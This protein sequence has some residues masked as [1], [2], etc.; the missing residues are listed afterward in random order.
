MVQGCQ[1]RHFHSLGVYSVPAYSNEW[2]PREMYERGKPAFDH[3]LKTYGAQNKAGY[4]DFIPRFTGADFDPDAWARLFKQAGAR[5][6]VPVAEHHD[7]FSMYDS[8]INPWNAKRMGPKRDVI[9]ELAAAFRRQELIFGLSSHRAEHWWF[10]DEGR[11]FPSDV[12]DP[13]YAGLYG[14]ARPKFPEIP[15]EMEAE[16]GPDEPYLKDWLARTEELTDKYHPQL[17]YFDWWIGNA[18]FEPYLR[19]FAAHY[20]NLGA[21]LKQGVAIDYKFKAFREGTAVLDV[22]RGSLAAIRPNFWQ[23]DTAVAKNSWGHTDAMDYKDPG[24][25]VDDLVDVVSK[26]GALLLNVGPKA[27]GTIPEHEQQML[28]SIGAWLGR[29]GEA[30]YGTRPWKIYG[31]GPTPI[32]EGTFNDGKRG[33]FTGRDIR[34]TQAKGKIYATVLADPGRSLVLPAL[35]SGKATDPGRVKSVTLL[36]YGRPL[37]WKQTKAG[38]SV[39][40]PRGAT[41]PTGYGYSFRITT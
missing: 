39:K 2:Y 7:G 12:Q 18:K 33:A 9:G 27:D 40:I 38:L 26:N 6:V 41:S 36:G 32:V 29:N 22:E 34:Y 28:R 25:I 4:K 1:I 10:F 23:T 16:F 21:L 24:D 17:V 5:F 13:R 30:I 11:K 37:H 3:H 19:Q 31:E 15:R 20:Y 14:P 8:A 35:G